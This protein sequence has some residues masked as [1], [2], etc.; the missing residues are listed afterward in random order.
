M[1]IR[2]STA[3]ATAGL[4]PFERLLRHKSVYTV[5]AAAFGLMGAFVIGLIL[6]PLTASAIAYGVVEARHRRAWIA[7]TLP[8]LR[9]GGGPYRGGELV[10]GRLHRA[11]LLV[12]AAGLGCFYWSW[13]CLVGWVGIGLQFSER[14]ELVALAVAGALVAVATWRSG[15]HLLRRKRHAVRFGR[16]VAAT[17]ALHAAF[18]LVLAAALGDASWSGPAGAF[19]ALS[20]ALAWLVVA[21]TRQHAPLFAAGRG[22]RPDARVLPAWLALVLS[23]R[24]AQR[25]ANLL[26]SA[27]QTMPGA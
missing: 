13:L 12:R 2:Q 1:H 10:P 25:R 8:A 20:L 6:L 19:A 5:F 27:S 15:V 14:G 7:L 21:A 22:Q 24:Q 9:I 26:V 18:V 23:K 11:P 3:C 16:R 17:A 4:R